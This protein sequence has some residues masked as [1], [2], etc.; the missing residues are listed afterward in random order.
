MMPY[1]DNSHQT[2]VACSVEEVNPEGDMKC[3]PDHNPQA[4]YLLA[5]KLE[6]RLHNVRNQ[7]TLHQPA[8]SLRI[9]EL[10]PFKMPTVS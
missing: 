9:D 7:K 6:E 1:C 8:R 5:I 3:V 4:G 2:C 10:V